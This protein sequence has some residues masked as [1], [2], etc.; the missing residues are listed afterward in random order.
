MYN[1]K[2]LKDTGA[3]IDIMLQNIFM[4]IDSILCNAVIL[5]FRGELTSAF[6]AASLS[7][8]CNWLAA[9]L[10]P[11]TFDFTVRIFFAEEHYPFN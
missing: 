5:F 2:L 4:Y 6:T 9:V 1:E 8:V 3:E 11:Q 10:Q 7:Q